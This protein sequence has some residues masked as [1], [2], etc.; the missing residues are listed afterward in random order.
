M[1]YED[2]IKAKREKKER[3]M[4]NRWEKVIM[5][6]NIEIEECEGKEW[7]SKS[8]SGVSWERKKRERK[9]KEKLLREMI[10]NIIMNMMR[11][12]E[13]WWERNKSERKDIK[14]TERDERTRGVR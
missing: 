13:R 5:K 14:I 9:E 7:Q 4:R 10:E 1:Y 2:N 6:E 8:Y 3:A 12:K 11:K